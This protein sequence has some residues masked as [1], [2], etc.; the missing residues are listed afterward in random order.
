MKRHWRN[1]ILVLLLL[2]LLPRPGFGQSLLFELGIRPADGVLTTLE[3][4]VSDAALPGLDA[5]DLPA[6]PATPDAV[7]D[8]YML[9][10]E[11]P[12]A[13]PNRWLRDIRALADLTRKRVDI[14]TA[15]VLVPPEGMAVEVALERSGQSQIPYTLKLMIPMAADIDIEVPWRTELYLPG[16]LQLMYW[17]LEQNDQVSVESTSWGG[18][19]SLYR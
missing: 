12:A 18:I 16:G 10:T 9:M 4:G 19:K 3:F 2:L 17:V 15:V 13:M 5:Y 7:W 14:W 11:A 1:D 8:A 6:P